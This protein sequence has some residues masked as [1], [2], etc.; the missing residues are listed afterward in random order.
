MKIQG[1]EEKK[2]KDYLTIIIISIVLLFFSG[3]YYSYSLITPVDSKNNSTT[4]IEVKD[5]YT[6]K[7]ISSLLYEKNII[8]S[9][10]M[11]LILSRINNSDFYVGNFEVSKSMST[12]DVLKFL[13]TKTNAKS[14]NNFIVIEG[15]NVL[16]IADDLEKKTNIKAKD[17]LKKL[18]DK[19]FINKMKKKFPDLITNELDS[20]KIKYK[21][22][23]YIY[24]AVYD[25]KS[26]SDVDLEKFLEK[27]LSITNNKIVPLYKQNKTEL[28]FNGKKRKLTI[29]E[30]ITLASILEKESTISGDNEKIAGVFINRLNK[31][32]LLQ[33]DPTVYYSLNRTNGGL[34]FEDLANNNIYNTYKYKGLTPGPISTVGEK[35][36]EALNNA[37]VHDYLYFLND[38]S[39]KAHFAKTFEEHEELAKK[40]IKNYVSSK[41]NN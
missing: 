10:T 8:K 37:A 17:F 19:E 30:Y 41:G 20:D 27:S 14:L 25:F 22:E 39:G 32:M 18:N 31:N 28:Y 36:Y 34:S 13:T 33:T 5:N 23:G 9:P 15:E 29:H 40:Y 26:L 24:P 3:I 4:I 2:K 16:K 7:E 11:F 1:L 6:S 12:N 35:S 21:L 38:D